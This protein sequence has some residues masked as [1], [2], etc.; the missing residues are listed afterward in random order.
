MAKF[1]VVDSE[2]AKVRAKAEL[3]ADIVG[4]LK[5]GDPFDGEPFAENPG[6]VKV[7]APPPSGFVP[8][9]RVR[10][11]EVTMAPEP[12]AP[13]EHQA[14]CLLVTKAAREHGPERNYLMAAAYCAS[15]NLT[16]VGTAT[17]ETVGPFRIAADDWKRGVAM[18]AAKGITDLTDEDRYR[19]NRQHTVAALLAADAGNRLAAALGRKPT[20]TELFFAQ[21]F[22]D[23]AE[24]ILKGDRSLKC[25]AAIAPLSP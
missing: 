3:G 5:K 24:Q 9:S 10:P 18:A 21:Q 19:A 15:K 2:G 7:I 14:F 1:V 13:E 6:F 17:S 12:I 11:T 23:G 22:G 16:D 4:Q 20:F 8:S 25:A